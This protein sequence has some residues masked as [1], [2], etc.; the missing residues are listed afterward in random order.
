MSLTNPPAN[1]ADLIAA[2]KQTA[3]RIDAARNAAKQVS[4]EIL[5]KPKTEEGR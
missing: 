3:R 1:V 2:A 5:A 4:A